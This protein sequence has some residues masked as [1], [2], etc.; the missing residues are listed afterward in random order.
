M[1]GFFGLEKIFLELLNK[2]ISNLDQLYIVK[3]ISKCYKYNITMKNQGVTDLKR[4]IA[5]L[6][7]LIFSVSFVAT[8]YSKDT[9]QDNILEIDYI[10]NEDFDSIAEGAS[11]STVSPV[12]KTNRIS[13]VKMGD[14]SNKAVEY[15][16]LSESDMYID[17]KVGCDSGTVF[18][19]FDLMYSQFG[20]GNTEFLLCFKDS[21]GTKEVEIFHINTS[22]TLC[23]ASGQKIVKLSSDKF[24]SFCVGLDLDTK[25]A[26]IYVNHK[27]KANA[28]ALSTTDFSGISTLRTHLYKVK[29]LEKPTIYI[30]NLL[31]YQLDKPLFRYTERGYSVKSTHTIKSDVSIASDEMTKAYMK[32]TVALYLGQNKIAIDGETEYLDP[33]NKD[34]KVFEEGGRAFV[35]VRF[36]SEALGY[37]VKWDETKKHISITDGTTTAELKADSDI[38]TVNNETTKMDAKVRIINGRAFVP[39]RYVCEAFGKKLTYDK[40]G[41][42][43]IAD[44]ENFFDFRGDLGIFRTLSGSLVFD[45]PS[46]KE[47]V[48][49]LKENYPGSS[50]PRIHINETSL[51]QIKE[52][53]KTNETMKKWSEDIFEIANNYVAN[54]PLEYEIAD[55]VRLLPIS[56]A[57]LE[58]LECL[59]FAYLISD[60]AR[61][62]DKAVSEM[63]NICSFPDWNPYHFLDTAEMMRAVATAY[64]WLYNY[65]TP[66]QREKIKDGIIKHGLSQVLEDYND[67]SGRRRSYKWAQSPEPDNWNLVCNGGSVIAA[68]AIA[69]DNEQI[70]SEVLDFAMEHIQK[71]ILLYGPDGA[72]YE[73]PGYWEYATS[74]YVGFMS[75]IYSVYNNTF[76]YIETPGVAQTGYYIS[77]LSGSQGVFNFHDSARS[78]V[79]S[80]V[81]HF[82]GNMVNDDSLSQ[83]RMNYIKDNDIS[84]TVRDMLWYKPTSHEADVTMPKDFYYRDTEVASMRSGWNHTGSVM[85]GL[86]SGKIQVYHG[87]MDAG[88]FIIDAYGTL[89][90]NDMGADDYNIKDNTWNLYRYRAEGHNT[91]VINPSKDGGQDLKAFPKID[92]FESGESSS[93][94]VTD[95]SDV[96]KAHAKDVKR[97]IKLTNN[98]KS[99]IVQDELDL[100]SPSEVKW[101]MHTPCEIEIAPDGKSARVKGDYRD[102]LV[103]LLDDI[104][105]SF[106]VMKAQPLPTSP[107]NDKQNKN[108]NF[109]KLVLSMT[110]VTTATIP[111]CFSFVASGEEAQNLYMPEVVPLSNW[112]LDKDS[113]SVKAPVLK[114]IKIGG[115]QIE[116]F[117]PE[118][119]VYSYRRLHGE[120]EVEITALSDDNVEITYPDTIPGVAKICVTSKDDP[121][122]KEW[123]FIQITQE[124]LSTAPKGYETMSI[125]DVRASSVPEKAN[126]PL[127]T[128]DNN[129]DTRWAADGAS[130]IIFELTSPGEVS[131][132]A[133]AVYQGGVNDGRKQY[134]K[135]HVSDDGINYKEIYEGNTSGETLEKELF[136]FAPVHARFIKLECNGSSV[137]TWNSITEFCAYSKAE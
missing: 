62:A 107:T 123:Y 55:G 6:T 18:L 12:P 99:I 16:L 118:T 7:L 73:G 59:A 70:A 38:I 15:K 132:I 43:V 88:Q 125:T 29:A 64:D 13:V 71:A 90:A 60:D 67:V 135:I 112:E 117:D 115:K 20:E 80:P 136:T 42:I 30:D 121:S 103:Y 46:G 120:P 49:L 122:L 113:E 84:A 63:L 74:Y 76:G 104:D 2:S 44:R 86:H 137:G 93:F 40:S 47:M 95:L 66:D 39:V 21:T 89:F 34:I 105:A 77:A 31:F 24:Y 4:I 5:F 26:D 133:L 14:G 50:H 27:K 110:D 96:Y 8:G 54:K 58:R 57:A 45:A 51:S 79:N 134:F 127:N 92:R 119:L 19:E 91:L 1:F 25:K 131:A 85:V 9:P 81:L 35:P 28:V 56:R 69:E 72:W 87:Q 17:S 36:V 33:V 68:L 53:I 114:E 23:T 41:L 75:A 98:R 102:M 82:L 10:L 126:V 116:N 83:I 94:A 108:T 106:S 124:L 130:H 109:R 52:Q 48:R 78:L 3:F 32:D 65:M 111:V 129:I 100:N 22:R 37:N 97:G 11:P 101:F 128:L 61:Y